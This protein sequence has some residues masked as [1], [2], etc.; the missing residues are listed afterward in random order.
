MYFLV[1]LHKVSKTYNF[2]AKETYAY[3]QTHRQTKR[4]RERHKMRRKKKEEEG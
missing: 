3:N 2:V 1:T 4:R